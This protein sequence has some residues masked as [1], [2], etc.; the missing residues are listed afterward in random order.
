MADESK[1]IEKGLDIVATQ[2]KQD[3]SNA[4][5]GLQSGD[6]KALMPLIENYVVPVV[7]AVLILIVGIIVAKFLSRVCSSPIRKRV[8][9]TFGKFVAKLIYYSV[10]IF[11]ILGILGMFGINVASFAAVIAA[12]GFA[13]GLAFQGTLSNFA[14]GVLLLVF[15]PFKINDIVTVAG[16]TGTISEIDLFTTT[17][18]TP[19]NR[20]IIVPNTTIASNTIENITHHPKRRVDVAIGVSYDA[21]IDETRKVLLEALD[22]ID[23]TVVKTSSPETFLV[24]LG[25]SS[26]N[27]EL[28]IWCAPVDYF[29]VKEIV[30]E[31]AKKALDEAGIDI[32]YPQMKIHYK[33]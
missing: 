7:S 13:V 10:V 21:D 17:F 22:G 29:K 19:D 11:V 31:K 30:T 26:V 27:W 15:R 5:E 18:D 4:F 8:D 3:V 9:E 33:A 14:S 1:T 25:D 16:I 23:Q 12:A 2:A 28:R 24:N 32:P 6:L 20:R